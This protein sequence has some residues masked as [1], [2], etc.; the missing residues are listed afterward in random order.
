MDSGTN[1]FVIRVPRDQYRNILFALSCIT[2]IK[3]LGSTVRCLRVV[4]TSRTCL[5]AMKFLLNNDESVDFDALQF[6]L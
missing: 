6:V 3:G 5:K 4:S 1:I 2:H